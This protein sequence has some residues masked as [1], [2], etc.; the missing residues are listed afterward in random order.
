MVVSV[1][2][3]S[4]LLQCT[5]FVVLDVHNVIQCLVEDVYFN[6]PFLVVHIYK[7]KTEF[8]FVKYKTEFVFVNVCVVVYH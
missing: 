4:L 5:I 2:M 8:V 6:R 7:Y 3:S 1:P